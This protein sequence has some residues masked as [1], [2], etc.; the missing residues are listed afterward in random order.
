MKVSWCDELDAP[1]L[2]MIMDHEWLRLNES[3]LAQWLRARGGSLC[4]GLVYLPD[5]NQR[6]LFALRWS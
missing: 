6:L 1:E 4:S 5:A 3:A 2:G